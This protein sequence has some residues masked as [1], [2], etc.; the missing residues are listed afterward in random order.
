MCQ[1]TVDHDR[2]TTAPAPASDR[3]ARRALA[4]SLPPALF[5]SFNAP[6]QTHGREQLITRHHAPPPA[7]DP[8]LMP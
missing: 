3:P 4:N 8:A 6:G 7:I 1:A 5:Q 2:Q